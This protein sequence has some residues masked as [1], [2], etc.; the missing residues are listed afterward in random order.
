[1]KYSISL[2]MYG[3]NIKFDD[4]KSEEYFK[5]DKLP[6]Y[7]FSSNSL[8]FLDIMRDILSVYLEDEKCLM[9]KRIEDNG[10]SIYLSEFHELQNFDNRGFYGIVEFGNHGNKRKVHD[11]NKIINKSNENYINEDEGV[12]NPYYFLIVIPK[13]ISRGFLILEQKRGIGIKTMFKSIFLDEGLKKFPKY[14]HYKIDLPRILPKE[15]KETFYKKGELISFKLIKNQIP[16]DIVD[17]LKTDIKR[18]ETEF[19][20]EGKKITPEDFLKKRENDLLSFQTFEYDLIKVTSKYKGKSKTFI[21]TDPTTIIPYIYIT[22]EIKEWDEG[23]P[24]LDSIHNVALEHLFNNYGK[25]F[26]KYR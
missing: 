9:N 19:K 17:D 5:L 3:I 1:M 23:N 16:E 15:L 22:D 6:D 18:I 14:A 26:D 21:L 11:V 20:L 10:K 7:N 2:A 4:S 8:D 12:F 25:I 13:N 24:K